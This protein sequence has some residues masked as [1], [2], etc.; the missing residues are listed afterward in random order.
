MYWVRSKA[1]KS[2]V[3][4][5]HKP[6]PSNGQSIRRVFLQYW[7]AFNTAVFLGRRLN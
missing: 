6:K 4:Q 5:R 7:N 3:Y 1:M 2:H